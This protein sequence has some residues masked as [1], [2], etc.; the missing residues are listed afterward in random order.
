MSA[1]ESARGLAQS[2]PW[3]TSWWLL[4]LRGA[5]W[6]CGSPLP[7]CFG[8]ASMVGRAGHFERVGKRQRPGAVHTLA[9]VEVAS[10]FTRSVLDCGSPLP[11]CFGGARVIGHAGHFERVG[12]RQRPGAVQYRNR[13]PFHRRT[14]PLSPSFA[15]S[16]AV[17]GKLVPGR[18]RACSGF[19]RPSFDLRSTF[20]RPSFDLGWPSFGNRQ[21]KPESRLARPE[22]S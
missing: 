7:L 19:V 5:F 14:S 1:W 17:I 20:V 22:A 3:R 6:E 4:R 15:S 16:S 21:T 10:P 8:G 9:D 13:Y 12:K 11:L 18:F 2:T